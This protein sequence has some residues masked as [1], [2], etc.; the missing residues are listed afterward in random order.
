[1]REE[2]IIEKFIPINNNSNPTNG[3]YAAIKESFYE[4]IKKWQHTKLGN[5]YSIRP[6]QFTFEI[7][8]KCNCNCKDCGMAANRL[9]VS[10]TV[11]S[12]EE[13]NSIIDNLETMGIPSYAITGGEPF[14]AFD[15]MCSMINYAKN[16][17]DVIKIIFVPF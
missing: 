1:M 10:R 12:T 5:K 16:K 14:L 17:V 15:K 2:N 7:T 8:N 11:L 13:L 3:K 4:D 6:I 9:K